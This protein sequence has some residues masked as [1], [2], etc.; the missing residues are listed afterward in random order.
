[1]K[2]AYSC[3]GEGFGHVSR[4]SVLLPHLE[5]RHEVGLFLPA[6][7]V[8][9]LAAK[10]GPRPSTRIPG[11]HFE[12]RGDR[13]RWGASFRAMLPVLVAFPLMVWR[14]ARQ[15]R[16]QSYQAVVSD[17]EPHLAWAG[18]LAGLPI[19]QINH[20]G[21]LTRVRVRGAWLGVVGSR[22]LEGPWSE[23]ILVSF[24]HG[25]VGPLLRPALKA[26]A[27][28][29]GSELLVH[30]KT[31]YRARALAVLRA[32]P[33][34]RYRVFPSPVENFDEALLDCAGVVSPAGHQVLAEALALGKPVLALPQIGQPEQTLNAQQLVATGR[35]HSGSLETFE[36]DLRRFLASLDT[37]ASAP[38]VGRFRFED[39]TPELL[40]RLEA[41]LERRVAG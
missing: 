11:L 8:E 4:L 17:Y 28:R 41:F 6:S 19:L 12:H 5:A 38:V 21:V 2:L 23:R 37:L 18:W 40:T 1:M 32:V 39:G 10:V 26:R 34:L 31:S 30:L 9:F 27:A 7:V 13:I 16:R 29:A 33:G 20:P 14:L 24:F 22:L 3:A 35:G 15:L 25:D 36:T